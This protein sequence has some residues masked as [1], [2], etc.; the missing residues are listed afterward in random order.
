MFTFDNKIKIREET[1]FIPKEAK[2]SSSIFSS[3][4]EDNLKEELG[5]YYNY[6]C[7]ARELKLVRQMEIIKLFSKGFNC[8]ITRPYLE[9][10]FK[11]NC[12]ETTLRAYSLEDFISFI[13]ERVLDNIEH[14]NQYLDALCIIFP[15]N[16][17]I[18]S[19]WAYLVGEKFTSVDRLDEGK[20]PKNFWSRDTILFKLDSWEA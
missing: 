14:Y 4:P 1:I 3:S 15:N 20:R 16:S 18:G 5:T 2:T 6:Y 12:K 9:Y 7:N 13:P 19:D 10:L 8:L 17:S 11:Q